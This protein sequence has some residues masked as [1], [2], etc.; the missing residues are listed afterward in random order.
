MWKKCGT[1]GQATGDNILRFMRFAC[2]VT[3]GGDKHSGYVTHFGFPLQQRL[4]KQP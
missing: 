4:H 2:W 3:Q 1:A